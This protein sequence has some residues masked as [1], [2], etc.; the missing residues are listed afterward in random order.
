MTLPPAFLE[1]PLTHRALHGAG[2]P[3]NAMSA[4]KAA[5]DH[6]Y[7]IEVDIQP[8]ADGHAMVFHDYDLGRLTGQAGAVGQQ[9]AAALNALPL[10]GGDGEGIPTLPQVLKVVAGQ[11]PLLI[12]VKDQDGAMGPNVGP[13]EQ[14]VAEALVGYGGPVAVMSFNPHSTAAFA[15]LAPD[16]PRGITTGGFAA[17]N[18]PTIGEERRAELRQI[19]DFDRVGAS[20]I[21]H[22]RRDLN[23]QVVADLKARGIP[24]LCWTI[25]SPEEEAE[26]R[27]I[28]DNVTFEG[29]LA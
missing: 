8:S 18:W 20:F 13:L 12:E 3:E 1:V 2:R 19:P 23:M 22:N 15:R 10:L 24:V 26:A 25:R 7:G 27:K 11:V 29:Y 28:A 5:I 14:A 4:I 17:E 21:S 6:G 16:V 9:T